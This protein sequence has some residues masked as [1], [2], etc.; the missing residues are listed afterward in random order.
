MQ[1]IKTKTRG[2]RLLRPNLQY[3]KEHSPI[4]AL[5]EGDQGLCGDNISIW[6]ITIPLVTGLRDPYRYCCHEHDLNYLQTQDWYLRHQGNIEEQT[7]AVKAQKE[8]DEAFT[9]CCY[10]ILKNVDGFFSQFKVTR[11][12]LYIAVVKRFGRNVWWESIREGQA[13]AG[14]LKKCLERN[15]I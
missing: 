7:R 2:L 9:L 5:P 6:G 4:Q 13:K 12:Y 3:I 8:C 1:N 11:G 10:K 15:K 14:N